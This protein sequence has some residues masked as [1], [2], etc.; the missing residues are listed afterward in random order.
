M[1]TELKEAA[2]VLCDGAVKAVWPPS[3]TKATATGL[4]F[5]IKYVNVDGDEIQH[6][7]QK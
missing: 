2:L 3:F 6:C 1:G 7:L 4:E 5:L